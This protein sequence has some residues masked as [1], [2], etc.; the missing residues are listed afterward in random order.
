[1]E[2]HTVDQN[3]HNEKSSLLPRVIDYRELPR[4]SRKRR[5]AVKGMVIASIIWIWWSYTALP[6]LMAI[7]RHRDIAEEN[8]GKMVNFAD[9]IPSEK[10][11]WH[12]CYDIHLCARLTVPMDY[13]RPLNVSK[14]NPKVHIA[15]IML[16][17]RNHATTKK[18]S[19]SPLLLNPGG[20]GGSGTQMILGFGPRIHKIVG[21]DQDVIGFDPRGIALTT[22]RTDCFSYPPSSNVLNPTS[23]TEE[24][25]Y[26]GGAF[27]RLVWELAS[28]GI[29]TANSSSD[30]LGKLDVRARA[31]ARLCE[32]KDALSGRDSIFKYVDTPN[33]ARDMLSIVDAWD[34][35]TDGMKDEESDSG[36][37]FLHHNP[38][39]IMYGSTPPEILDYPGL[40]T[41]G[42]LVYW[43]FSYGTLLGATFAAMFP[44]RVGR[45]ILDGVVDADQYIAPVWLDSIRDS[46]AVMASFFKYCHEAGAKCAFYRTNDN[47]KNLEARYYEIM[48]KLKDNPIMA[49]VPQTKMPTII[50][51]SDIKMV[52]FSA[53]YSPIAAFPLVAVVLDHLDQGE[54]DSLGQFIRLPSNYDMKP[55]LCSSAMPAWYYPGEAQP[56]IMCSDKRYPLNETLSHLETMFEQMSNQSSWADVWM[57][58]MIGCD[59]WNIE[60][61]DPPMRWDDH[62]ARKKKPIKTSFPLLFISNTADPVTPLLAGLKMARKFVDAGLIEQQSEGHC[63]IS[64][65]SKC[66]IDKVRAYL[67]DGK[68]PPPPITGDKGKELRD[69]KWE[70]CERDEWPWRPYE[71]D[72]YI[73]NK[74]LESTVEAERLTA[75]KG[76]QGS[77]RMWRFWGRK[78]LY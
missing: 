76:M 49:I 61:V 41:K 47:E 12:P 71:E 29:G 43:G 11:E 55:I 31:L 25:D 20:P 38:V 16:P 33:V 34:A 3:R 56:A 50:S 23:S 8:D 45:V 32:E 37:D 53:L 35:W 10:L 46:D 28:R 54:V 36:D 67:I 13:H 5:H 15:L 30:S 68:V 26:G 22:P 9:I 27:N 18:Y 7:G 1:M 59:G 42:K 77:T 74:G 75:W 70:R 65:V 14:D 72:E 58:V 17:G 40:D 57:T 19:T 66:T 44:D 69:G 73:A 21:D 51:H 60:A 39:E 6:A 24:N 4:T 62:P 2:K 78:P 52:L 63:S 64:T 48:A